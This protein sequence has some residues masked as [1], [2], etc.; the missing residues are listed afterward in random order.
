MLHYRTFQNIDPPTLASI[1]RSH[2]GQPGLAHPVSVDLLEQ[3]VFGKLYFDYQGLIL[4]FEGDRPVGFV[5][6]GFGPNP[7]GTG[8]CMEQGAICMLL[9]RPDCPVKEVASGLLSE[10][11]AYLRRRGAKSVFG[12]SV[13]PLTPFYM[14]MYGGCALP[15]V[16]ESDVITC[17]LYRTEGYQEVGRTLIFTLDLDTF[18]APVDRQQLQLRRKMGVEAKCDP[19]PSSWWDACT[20]GEFVLTR[21]EASLKGSGTIAAWA[22]FRDM[23][24]GG[25]GHSG[26]IEGLIDVHVAPAEQ[27]QGLGTF[28]LSEAFRYLASQ[29]AQQIEAQTTQE[30]VAGL[31]LFRKLG[32]RQTDEAVIFRKVL[33]G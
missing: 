26:R 13:K 9:V 32:F 1:W 6:A 19:S 30:N 22:M 20:T 5:H 23:G 18:R 3:L 12:G 28:L 2:A 11:E 25:M 4:A 17:D 31:A 16:L 7:Q 27:R 14:G 24:P 33:D 8:L 29:G 21:F 15:G 10:S